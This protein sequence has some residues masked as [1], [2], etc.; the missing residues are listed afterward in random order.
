MVAMRSLIVVCALAGCEYLFRLD[1]VQPDASVR[2]TVVQSDGTDCSVPILDVQFPS[3]PSPCGPWANNYWNN[4][5]TMVANGQLVIIPA[6][7]A[8][9]YAGCDSAQNL[10]FG[11]NGVAVEVSSIIHGSASFTELQL[12]M[13]LEVEIVADGIPKLHFQTATWPYTEF[14]PPIQYDPTLM[15]WWRL[16]PRTGQVI[17]EYSPD[18]VSWTLFGALGASI[19]PTVAVEIGAG[20][21]DGM[22]TNEATFQRLLVCP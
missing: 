20:T 12:H 8:N 6:T 17:A 18:G 9:S 4:N 19:P 3:D 16:R 22:S 13:G 21:T 14:V 1:E 5:A 7:K 10:T 2:D 15:L 11:V